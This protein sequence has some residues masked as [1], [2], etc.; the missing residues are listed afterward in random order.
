MVNITYNL[1]AAHVPAVQSPA[2]YVNP[3][4]EA[5][6]VAEAIIDGETDAGVRKLNRN[7]GRLDLLGQIGAGGPY[8]VQQGTG[9]IT[10][11]SGLTVTISAAAFRAGGVDYADEQDFA[12]TGG[13]ANYLWLNSSGAV[14]RASDT[15]VPSGGAVYLYCVT[16]SGSAVTGIDAS[17]RQELRS[18]VLFRRTADLAEPEDTPPEGVA[19]YAVTNDGDSLY[20][21]DGEQYRLI[22]DLT[23]SLVTNLAA[24][25][26]TVTQDE[27]L[28]RKLLRTLTQL[29]GPQIVADAELQQQFALS[30]AEA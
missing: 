8:G 24:L 28:F 5:P 11:T 19:F 15:D 4:D 1:T 7:A 18:G 16:C 30:L 9:E 22:D 27:R 29:F 2:A 21:W 12:C 6:V 26:S 13:T 14:V 23:G 10:A 25:D 17:G 3:V 20:L